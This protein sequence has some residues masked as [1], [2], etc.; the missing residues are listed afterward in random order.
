MEESL[1]TIIPNLSIGV[2]S[3]LGLVYTVLKFLQ[4]LDT[5]AT[6]H[7]EAM[8]ERECALREVEKDV[9]QNLYLHLTQSTAALQE[10]TKVL[11][12]VMNHLDSNH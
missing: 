9:R 6:Q 1:L 12:R 2:I 7:N 11:S 5:R 3:I 8:K 10:N 4:A